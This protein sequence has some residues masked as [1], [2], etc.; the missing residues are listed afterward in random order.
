MEAVWE[1]KVEELEDKLEDKLKEERI[2]S[3]KKKIE[4]SWRLAN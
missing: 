4:K 1:V 2:R 3:A